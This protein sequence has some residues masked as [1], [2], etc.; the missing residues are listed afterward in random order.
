[1]SNYSQKAKHPETGKWEIADYLDDYY[2]KHQ[3]GV[4]FSDGQVFPEEEIKEWTSDWGNTPLP[5]KKSWWRRII[6]P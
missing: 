4:K 6:K 3:Y 5:P 2:G 1:M